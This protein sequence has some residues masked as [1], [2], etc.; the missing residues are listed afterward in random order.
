MRERPYRDAQGRPVENPGPPCV[1]CGYTAGAHY[2]QANYPVRGV[3]ICSSF[4][5]PSTEEE[6]S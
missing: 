3:S 1:N 6:G 5:P 4:T 2:S